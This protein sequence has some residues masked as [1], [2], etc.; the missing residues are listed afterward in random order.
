MARL[1]VGFRLRE[2]RKQ[3]G[4][5]QAGL[6]GE[7]GISPSYLNLIE[8]GRR[9]VAGALL[10]RLAA[11]LAIDSATLSGAEDARLVQ[12]LAEIATDPLLRDLQLEQ[13]AAQEIVGRHVNWGR[14]LLRLHRSY[15]GAIGVAETLADRLAH[16][17]ELVEV[18]HELLTRIT[19]I[20][21]FSEILSEHEDIDPARR[22]RFVTLLAEESG[23]LG[24]T[25]RKLFERLSEQ[26]ADPRP[27]TPAQEV[28]DFFID[29]GNHFPALE[30]A[31]ERLAGLL[32]ADELEAGLRARLRDV[33]GVRVEAASGILAA[34]DDGGVLSADGALF[35]VPVNAPPSTLR[36]LLARLVFW[37]EHAAELRELAGDRRLTT[38]PAR[39]R[40]ALAL[41]RYGAGALLFPYEA[42]RRAAEESRYDLERLA[43]LF[44]ASFEQVCHRLVTLRRPG[45]QGIPFA[46]LRVD[47]AGNITK[48]FSLPTLRLPRQGGACPLWIVYRAF[49]APGTLLTQ[50][51][52]LPDGRAF[53]FVARA[54]AK[55]SPYFGQ[56]AEM[57]SVLIG[58][59]AIHADRLVYG[60]AGAAVE[61]GINCHVCPRAAC[62]QR[63]FPSALPPQ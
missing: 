31:A 22:A 5:T 4:I 34:G 56:P 3:L 46:F 9:E 17:S 54:V 59:D 40:A 6:A 62:P 45:A 27:T 50:R 37:L 53:V 38:D 2:R 10:N 18:S 42:F 48:R 29:R 16:D 36:F 61:T 57:H 25:A 24:E 33:H 11:A 13:D 19:S 63:A 26:G 47:P 55:P 32:E 12:D 39:E 52:R 49:Q 28:D 44:G 60:D 35:R 30:A 20:R 41:A 7:V 8:H 21:S 51:I 14:A 1:P 15:A 58:C 23:R 43:A